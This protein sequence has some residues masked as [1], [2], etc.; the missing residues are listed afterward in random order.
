MLSRSLLLALVSVSALSLAFGTRETNPAE[1]PVQQPGWGDRHKAKLAE[2]KNHQFDLLM[3]GD[4]ITHNFENPQYQATWQKYFG[5]RNALDLGYSGARTENLIWNIEN[6]E[7][8]GQNPKVVTLLI[9]TNNADEHNFPTHHTAEQ[10]FGGTRAVVRLIREKCPHAK[11]I[12]IRPFPFGDNPG[13]NSRDLVLTKTAELDKHLT[14]NHH[15]Y[16]CDINSIFLN[17]DGTMNKDLMPDGLHPNPTGA[18][19]WAEA[20]EPLLSKVMGDT[21]R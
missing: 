5:S 3:I 10:I 14:D 6:G 21:P 4:S 7:L 1:V 12:L 19:K 11:I 9:G 16:W 13:H 17:P 15:V 8:D 20:M 18:Q 2:E